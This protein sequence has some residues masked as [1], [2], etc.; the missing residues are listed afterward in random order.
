MKKIYDKLGRESGNFPPAKEDIESFK[1]HHAKII[2]RKRFHEE[3][4]NIPDYI[5]L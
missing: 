2:L 3:I 1:E 4:Q 5:K